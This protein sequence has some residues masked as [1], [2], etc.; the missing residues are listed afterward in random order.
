MDALT[1]E[2]IADAYP[3]ARKAVLFFADMPEEVMAELLRFAESS[4][5]E[6]LL[7]GM[8][9]MHRRVAERHGWAKSQDGVEPRQVQAQ[10]D[11]ADFRKFLMAK[12]G[13]L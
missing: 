9:A 13:A 8:K 6:A 7:E 5:L 10:M 3:G 12:L 11:T 1:P 2:Q 4:G